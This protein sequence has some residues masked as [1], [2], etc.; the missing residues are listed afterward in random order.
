MLKTNSTNVEGTYYPLQDLNYGSVHA[1]K[2]YSFHILRS[3][4]V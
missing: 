3:L 1:A 2:S 4:I